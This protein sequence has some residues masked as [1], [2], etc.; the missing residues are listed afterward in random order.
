MI[1]PQLSWLL[2]P[3]VLISFLTLMNVFAVFMLARDDL[4]QRKRIKKLEMGIK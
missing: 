1:E 2:V 4:D 3:V